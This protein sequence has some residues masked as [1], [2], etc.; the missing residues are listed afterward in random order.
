MVVSSRLS[1]LDE[2]TAFPPWNVITFLAFIF[3]IKNTGCIFLIDR[4]PRVIP[5][6]CPLVSPRHLFDTVRLASAWRQDIN[7][8]PLARQHALRVPQLTVM[9]STCQAKYVI[10]SSWYLCVGL[11][12][13][14]FLHH[15]F[16]HPRRLKFKTHL[17]LTYL[18]QL[19]PCTA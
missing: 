16:Q 6:S 8:H 15:P 5:V 17:S 4:W 18:N 3:F 19:W 11:E 10:K 2:S 1:E 13:V 14:Y 7:S 9:G 12:R